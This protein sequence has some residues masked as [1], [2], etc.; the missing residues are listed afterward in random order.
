LTEG[1][2]SDFTEDERNILIHDI[3]DVTEKMMQ[4]IV[5][6]RSPKN[7]AKSSCGKY[8]HSKRYLTRD[9]ILV[10]IMSGNQ[11]LPARPR[12]F[13]VK[14][15]VEQKNIERHGLF[16]ML[17]F[18]VRIYILNYKKEEF[19]FRHG[20]PRSGSELSEETRGR[21]DSF[22]Q[23]TDIYQ[24][25]DKMLADYTTIG[26]I[27]KNLDKQKLYDFLKYSFASHFYE[28]KICPEKFLES[29]KPYEKIAEVNKDKYANAPLVLAKDL[30]P[31]KINILAKKYALVTLANNSYNNRMVYFVSTLL[32]Y[33]EGYQ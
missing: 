14:M 27:D 18:L 6:K 25:I 5:T 9:T 19:K 23:R 13:R 29:L 8:K 11:T 28:I 21:K 12:D 3:V 2:N 15:P 20:R 16:D 31:E 1:N 17:Q 4:S 24:I 7:R 30:T 32:I 33:G 22:Y 26:K 10:N